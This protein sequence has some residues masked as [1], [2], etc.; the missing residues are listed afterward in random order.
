MLESDCLSTSL[1]WNTFFLIV[2]K[3]KRG[4]NNNTYFFFFA[5]L[6]NFECFFLVLCFLDFLCLQEMLFFHIYFFGVSHN[7][8]TFKDIFIF[9]IQPVTYHIVS[10]T[11][12]SIVVLLKRKGQSIHF[13][14]L[15]C[16]A[17]FNC[18][19]DL[20]FSPFLVKFDYLLVVHL[21]YF[22]LG[23][24]RKVSRGISQNIYS[25][26]ITFLR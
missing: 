25:K 1:L 15:F 18:R 23:L 19:C 9:Q 21:F 17:C 24:V 20:K 8:Y 4:K 12:L 6:E 10:H 2:Q 11:C 5:V 14:F 22:L 26:K 3:L 7:V 13:L 16:L